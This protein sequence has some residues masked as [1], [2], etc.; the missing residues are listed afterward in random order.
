MAYE[1]EVLNFSPRVAT[2][3]RLE[4]LADGPDGEVVAVADAE[5]LAVTTVV[6]MDVPAG[7][8]PEIP[9]GRTGLILVDDTSRACADVPASVTHRLSATFGP[10]GP[11]QEKLAALWPEESMTL[12]GG[13][14]TT[15]TG[16][17]RW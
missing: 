2:L 6:V 7:P 16:L 1:L 5:A 10:V 11:G 4:T 12:L 3:T 8:N 17:A 15:G 14:V 13:P 9:V